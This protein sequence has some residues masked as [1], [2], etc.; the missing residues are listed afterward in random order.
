MNILF[1]CAGRRSYLLNYFKQELND[2]DLIFATDMSISAPAMAV[3]DVAITVLPV[4]EQGYVDSLLEICKTNSIDALISLNDLELPI[5]AEHATKFKD[6]NVELIV[7]SS[8]V[9][10]ICFDKLKTIKFAESLGIKTPRTYTN[11]KS[12]QNAIKNGELNFPLVVKPRWGSA[13]IG[14]EFPNNME[15]L[16]LSFQL[17]FI[18]LKNSILNV[19]S[20]QDF[21]NSL[22]IQE[23][24]PG[25]EYGVDIL[26]DF[27]F[28][29]IAVYA[30]EKLSMRA[31]ETDKSVL[32]KNHDL[33]IVGERIGEAL[34]HKGNLDCDFFVDKNEVY[35]LEMNPR[36]GGGYPF[37]HESGGNFVK[38]IINWLD[39]SRNPGDLIKKFD[40]TFAKHDSLIKCLA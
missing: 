36:F 32:R 1:T 31:G 39:P 37:T 29:N 27:S 19:A 15:E 13:S 33:E 34:K 7:P 2:S 3:A 26:N 21:E 11:L 20:Q 5:L 28:Q 9:I 10:D 6:I 40:N 25:K 24:L 35:L 14:I 18:K 4:Y 23:T 12:A 38:R 17:S 8:E 22:L 30:K 16:E